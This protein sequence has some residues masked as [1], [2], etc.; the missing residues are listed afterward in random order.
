MFNN[1]S[2]DVK[3]IAIFYITLISSLIPL[4]LEHISRMLS[5]LFVPNKFKFTHNLYM[6][7]DQNILF[8]SSF[9]AIDIEQRSLVG[10]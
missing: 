1:L 3:I 10:T 7:L 2:D 9:F 4:L 5:F 6:H 8:Y